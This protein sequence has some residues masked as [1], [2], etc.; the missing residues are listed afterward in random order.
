MITKRVKA[1]RRTL[2]LRAKP[3][4]RCRACLI[5]ADEAPDDF[6]CKVAICSR[7]FQLVAL[8]NGVII[9]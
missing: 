3:V 9:G 2:R 7:R 6:T 8:N 5:L 1:R 4:P